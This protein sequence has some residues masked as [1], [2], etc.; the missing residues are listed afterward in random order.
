MKRS[1][2]ATISANG[3]TALYK[4]YACQIKYDDGADLEGVADSD[5]WTLYGLSGL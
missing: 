1:E 3:I 5:N 4:K 2:V